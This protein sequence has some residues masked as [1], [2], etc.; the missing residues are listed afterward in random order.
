MEPHTEE[1]T[2]DRRRDWQRRVQFECDIRSVPLPLEYRRS[3]YPRVVK[4]MLERGMAA[5]LLVLFS[6][7]MLLVALAIRLSDGGDVLFTQERTGYLGKRFKLYKFR[8]MVPNAEELKKELLELNE[9]APDSP[10]FKLRHDPRVTRLGRFL[11]KTSIDEL[12]NLI[13]VVKGD[14]NLVGPRPTSFDVRTYRM[15]HYPRLAVKPGITGLWQV[16]GRADV[17]FDE[18]SELD[19]AY[20]RQLS[21]KSDMDLIRRTVTAVRSGKGAR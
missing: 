6:P 14:M 9:H 4:P 17:D 15:E 16:S 1:S 20:I 2:Q 19:V 3:F 12:P 7:V 8:T 11:R 5:F 21:L 13:N 10:D 18:R